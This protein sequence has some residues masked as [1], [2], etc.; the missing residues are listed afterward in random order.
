MKIMR[1]NGEFGQSSGPGE[2]QSPPDGPYGGAKIYRI[3]GLALLVISALLVDL[4]SGDSRRYVDESDYEELARSIVHR[5]DFAGADGQLTMAR[6]PGYPAVIALVYAIIERPIA[7][8]VE[9]AVILILAVLA[10]GVL[11]RRIE[12]RA[13]VLVPYLALAYP[14]LIYTASVLYPQILGCLLLTVTL[15]LIAGERITL[16]DT[17]M[18]GI[19]YGVLILAIPYFILLLPL[20]GA[21]IAFRR[22]D[23]S[24]SG[25][26]LAAAMLGVSILVVG[27]WTARNYLVFHA[28]VPV[29]ANN[30]I[31]L[32]IGNSAV[33][34]PNSGVTADVLP[35]CKD[36]RTKMSE[37]EFDVT[38]RRCALD[39]IL[40]HPADA[41][42]L[43]VRKLVN[44]F[45]FRN[46]L[47]TVTESAPW[48]DWV[49]FLTYYPLLM[50]ALARAALI[51]RFP[52]SRAETF[53][54]MLYFL[55][56]FAS[57]IFFTRLRFRIPFDFLLIGVNAAFL[58]RLW[59]L[60][61]VARASRL[62]TS[63]LTRR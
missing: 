25:V 44:Y 47:A 57:A 61:G 7:A 28:V 14:I 3:L 56:A 49:V 13:D 9:N 41:A 16:R 51:R 62:P 39:W 21:F 43:Y 35:L 55:N 31:N 12:P 30:G 26:K 34:T 29:S 42:R 38:L 46:E 22:G 20:F 63:E 17:L 45:N 36:A 24:R 10:L 48:R 8:K 50:I 33:T 37:Y 52:F 59:D 1:R 18:A 53:I 11:A 60:R 6:P 2:R 5:H 54:Y 40:H 27:A 32:L 19:T 4:Q 58:V 15:L 23:R